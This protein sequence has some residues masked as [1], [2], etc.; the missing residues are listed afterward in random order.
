[1]PFLP[2]SAES[3]SSTGSVR[4]SSSS[5]YSS[6][7]SSITATSSKR[8]ILLVQ[9]QFE[10]AGSFGSECQVKM[11][12]SIAGN[13]L[14]DSEQ[15]YTIDSGIETGGFYSYFTLLEAD[16]FTTGSVVLHCQV[17][18]VD[19]NLRVTVNTSAIILIDASSLSDGEQYAYSTLTSDKVLTGTNS[20]EVTLSISSSLSN[21]GDWLVLSQ[22]QA[23]MG[24]EENVYN[25]VSTWRGQSVGPSIL[26]K[27][28]SATDK[29][30]FS[31]SFHIG[32]EFL[33]IPSYLSGETLN[34]DDGSVKKLRVKSSVTDGRDTSIT[35]KS[36]KILALRLSSFAG[37][38]KDFDSG[39]QNSG[40]LSTKT[41]ITE[42]KTFEKDISLS[43]SEGSDVLARSVIF[44][45]FIYKPIF[46]N[47][48]SFR[49]R[50]GSD[51]VGF[52]PSGML[53]NDIVQSNNS[54]DKY[55]VNFYGYVDENTAIGNKKF[56][57]K[58]QSFFDGTF[59]TDVF[60]T[61][62]NLGDQTPDPLSDP[63]TR[64][65]MEP[66]GVIRKF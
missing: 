23:E 8:Y 7:L 11:K 39:S 66:N 21:S 62:I 54:G 37:F 40:N 29:I 56:N 17:N 43:A 2:S 13:D 48:L 50:A 27:S 44:A 20:D 26:V 24:D 19:S 34:E 33:T 3:I 15:F 6:V 12:V 49:Y 31:N 52:L 60:L 51:T 35:V 61:V 53:N 46:N 38:V 14:E 59:S 22:T 28:K 25:K 65:K 32:N 10:R 41:L 30:L 5:S 36:S 9:S 57:I 16:S 55:P 1:M 58:G 47:S 64:A 45:S 18:P 63:S 4:I 42:G